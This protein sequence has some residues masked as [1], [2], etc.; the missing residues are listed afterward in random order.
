[1][2]LWRA[3]VRCEIKMCCFRWTQSCQG[4]VLSGEAKGSAGLSPLGGAGS[5]EVA[6]RQVGTE[7]GGCWAHSRSSDDRR[8]REG[9]LTVSLSKLSCYLESQGMRPVARRLKFYIVVQLYKVR[10]RTMWPVGV[11]N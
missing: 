4:A 8:W 9:R 6:E 11:K 10:M 7:Q 1:M 3:F 5:P 2:L